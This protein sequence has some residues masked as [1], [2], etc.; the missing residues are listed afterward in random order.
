MGD[1][2]EQRFRDELPEK[3]DFSSLEDLDTIQDEFEKGVEDIE[4][5]FHAL[6]ERTQRSFDE[7]HS[8]LKVI[9]RKMYKNHLFMGS[10]NEKR[11]EEC[12]ALEKSVKEEKLKWQEEKDLIAQ[13]NFFPEEMVTLEVSGQ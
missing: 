1:P 4:N 9:Y 11:L 10:S 6:V 7:K 12:K 13:N 5:Q 2:H 8:H 3:I